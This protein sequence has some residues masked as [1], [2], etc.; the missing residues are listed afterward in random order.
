MDITFAWKY[1]DGIA[2]YHG[3]LVKL[4]PGSAL[5]VSPYGDDRTHASKAYT[6]GLITVPGD[7]TTEMHIAGKVLTLCVNARHPSGSK[8]Y[9]IS[10][11]F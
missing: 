3:D 6:K 8:L 4:I 7:G 11:V 10:T 1:Q 2:M 5:I 9:Q